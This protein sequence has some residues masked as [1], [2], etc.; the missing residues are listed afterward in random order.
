MPLVIPQ[1]VRSVIDTVP[2]SLDLATFIE[3]ADLIITEQLTSATLSAARLKQIELYLAAHFAAISHER[4]GLTTDETGDTKSEL[5]DV[6]EAGF[7]MTR[8]GIAAVQLDT[9]GVLKA[10]NEDASTKVARFTVV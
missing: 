10:I 8:Y 4:G 7:A 5:S 1:E 9:S 6:Y 3:T 2:G